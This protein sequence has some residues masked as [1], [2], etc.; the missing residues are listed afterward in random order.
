MHGEKQNVLYHPKM[1]SREIE[2]HDSELTGIAMYDG[3]LTLNFSSVYIHESEGVS[4]LDAG[5]V[6][7]QQAALIIAGTVQQGTLPEFPCKLLDGLLKLDEKNIS[8]HDPHLDRLC[9]CHR[10]AAGKL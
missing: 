9:G 8:K 5:T 4:G 1:K 6:W 10:V 3:T 2:I 7:V